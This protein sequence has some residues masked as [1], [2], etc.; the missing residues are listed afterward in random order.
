M[1]ISWLEL[2]AQPN[3]SYRPL[4]ANE[5]HF[6]ASSCLIVSPAE[7]DLAP[8]A[9]K[10][11]HL[12]RTTTGC[13]AREIEYRSHLLIESRPSNQ[14]LRRVQSSLP[15]DM[16]T[17]LSI[18]VMLQN[19]QA[20]AN[21]KLESVKLTRLNDGGMAVD[22]TLTSQGHFAVATSLTVW[23]QLS[24]NGPS[25]KI[26]RKSNL[27]IYPETGRRE[28]T[29]PLGFATLP[30]GQMELLLEGTDGILARRIFYIEPPK[31]RS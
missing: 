21:A 5:A 12:R 26:A 15:V 28:V 9:S 8:G 30:G 24:D 6:A 11:V 3:G 25:Q 2:V 10:E 17:A 18:P 19:S 29:L 13:T 16:I 20:T 27:T 14:I 22:A 31:P 23:A 1:T 7:F 4:Q